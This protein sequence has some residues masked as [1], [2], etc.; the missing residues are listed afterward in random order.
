VRVESP[1]KRARGELDS[2][3]NAATFTRKKAA[4]AARRIHRVKWPGR[5]AQVKPPEQA[6]ELEQPELDG[7]GES[8]EFVGGEFIGPAMGHD[9]DMSVLKIF[10]TD[11]AFLSPA[12]RPLAPPLAPGPT[13]PALPGG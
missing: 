1:S 10:E 12:E 11:S 13:P 3:P 5:L 2:P 6:E 9:A 8:L 7:L 4:S